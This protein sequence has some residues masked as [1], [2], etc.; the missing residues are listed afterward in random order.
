MLPLRCIERQGL[1]S[2][3]RLCPMAST[4]TWFTNL[5]LLGK[6]AVPAA[7]MVIVSAGIILLAR[8]RMATLADNTQSIVDVRAARAVIALQMNL[9]LDEATI[10]E[11]NIIIETETAAMAAQFEHFKGTKQQALTAIDRLIALAD[12]DARR[13]TNLG[14]K[15]DLTAFFGAAERSD[16]DLDFGQ[17]SGLRG[18]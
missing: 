14:I 4:M 17:E 3:G 16:L 1:L 7:V 5:R 10:S 6:L 8:D 18:D 9:A 13:T 15:D 12:T 2:I 11:K